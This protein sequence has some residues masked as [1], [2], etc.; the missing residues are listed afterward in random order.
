MLHGPCNHCASSSSSIRSV[1]SSVGWSIHTTT[2]L[3]RVLTP[4]ENFLSDLVSTFQVCTAVFVM[5]FDFESP[6]PQDQYLVHFVCIA[7][8]H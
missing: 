8:A 3:V 1:T 7:M 6:R 2:M 4:V 5:S